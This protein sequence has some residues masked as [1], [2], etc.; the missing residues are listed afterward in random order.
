MFYLEA[1]ADE[2]SALIPLL[3][4]GGAGW[5]KYGDA[6]KEAGA[7]L[8]QDTVDNA[9]KAKEAMGDF[10][11]GV[12]GVTNTL[13]ANAA[14]AI[15]FVAENLD[16]LV[17][18]GLIVASVFAGRMITSTAATT[19]AFIAGRIEAIKYQMALA[20]M[21]GIATTT[22]ARLTALSTASRLL[23]LAGGLP[24]LAIA[25]AGVAA[26]F[27]LM[28]SSS[29]QATDSLD[30]QNK[31]VAEL[32]EEYKK[33]E[34]TQQRVL[35]REAVSQSEK[36]TVAYREQK[37]EL[38]GL[39]DSIR[40]SSSVSDESKKKAEALFEQYRQGKITAGQLATGI[41]GL[42]DVSDQLKGSID[43]QAGS[44]N[45][46]AAELNKKN[47]VV[48]AY[49]GQVSSAAILTDNMGESLK[50]VGTSAETAATKVSGL[51]KAYQEYMAKLNATT[52]DNLMIKGSMQSGVS[53]QEARMRQEL[54]NA[55]NADPNATQTYGALTPAEIAGIKSSIS[56]E[57]N[58]KNIVEQRKKQEETVTKEKE[59][60]TKQ[61]L[62]QKAIAAASNEQT[63]N[64]L[65][66][67]Q[68][69]SKAGLPD[70]AARYLTAEIGREGSYQNKNLFGSHKDANNGYANT[71]MISWQKDRSKALMAF[72]RSQGVIDDK[73]QIKQT[74]E[75]LDAQAEFLVN[76][77]FSNKT[78]SKSKNALLS[79]N[80]YKD[81]QQTVGNNFI[82][83]DIKGSR[84]SQKQVTSNI[85]RM[86]GYK[87]QLDSL[88]GTD[89][90][91]VLNDF[92]KISKIREDFIKAQEQQEQNRISLREAYYTEEEKALAEHNKRISDLNKAGYSDA[93]LKALLE[94]ENKRYEDEISKRPEILKRVQDS[95]S[96]LNESFLRSSDNDLQADLNAVDEKWKQP[97]AD[98]A[99]L[100]MSEPD[101]LQ[102]N[103]Y[104]QMLVKID[105]VIDQE[106]LTLQ[107]NDAMKQLE[108]LQSLRQQ[109]QD[110]LKLQFE[111]GQISRPQFAEGLQ[112]IDSDLT[113]KM[114]TLAEQAKALAEQLGDAFSV[115]KV[116]SFV[117]GL[118]QVDASFKQF[119]PTADQL[120]ERIAGG[121][122]D[123]IM[124]WADGTKSASDAFREFASN[125]LRE[126]AQ[127]ILKQMLFNAISKIGGA[128]G[129][130]LGG[131][132]A[133]G[134]GAAFGFSSGGY[135][136]A[137]SKYQPAG[138]VHADE[139]VIRKESTSQAGAKE[140]LS[141]FNRYG[142]DA[143]NKF[144]GYA[145]GGLVDAPNITV[146]DIQAPKLN[147]PAAQI[148]SATSFNANQNFYLVDDPARILDVLKSGASQE[149]LVVMMSRDPAKFK[150]AL[151][152]G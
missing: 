73:G 6:A 48:T 52:M 118:T 31:S 22:A 54:L 74:Q 84:L 65:M 13:F 87:N 20:S 38:L 40:H 129:G 25:A 18:A 103:E 111:S 75:A 47:Q 98:L 41:N 33:L 37:N 10:Q 121:L 35:L 57:E 100:M 12:T 67:Y 122:T 30:S 66:V 34:A 78:Y 11:N 60:Q 8:S 64:M 23:T 126:I 69:L 53:E 4:D 15:V 50:N 28:P 110:T 63:R 71:G 93:E 3:N 39:V 36:L 27:L 90:N 49:G 81:L 21:A 45:K 61:A 107:F 82:G 139:F 147:D 19:L 92:S 141:S 136:G 124:A 137:G 29:D 5:K 24:G 77:L 91:A 51:G 88:L 86:D 62:T 70:N 79:G 143:L 44:A 42:K 85:G 135:T 114:Q 68:A 59:K 144:K 142:M 55:K 128:G 26:S 132:I 115:E 99:S 2:G 151:K 43:S 101:P 149:N 96:S 109:K 138:I 80:G 112:A 125:F 123:S 140:F 102:A 95:L 16:V 56:A 119:L 133:G 94:K 97:K 152:I 1:I 9:K 104:Q 130:G 145:D 58:V 108:E 127:M 7:I 105:F 146:P 120:N 89:P 17:R 72:L 113:P 76:E 117:A 32:A 134:I 106:K 46:A 150:S 83:W 14:P 131:M 116:N 148:A